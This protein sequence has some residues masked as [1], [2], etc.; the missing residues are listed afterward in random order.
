MLA[1]V[2]V[3]GQ[4]HPCVDEAAA[5][6]P[7]GRERDHAQAHVPV[8]QSIGRTQH[9]RAVQRRGTQVFGQMGHVIGKVPGQVFTATF[10][11]HHFL[12]RLG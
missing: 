7:V 5:A 1:H 2:G 9:T 8:E 6:Q 11:Y 4:G 12:P 3:A 10:E